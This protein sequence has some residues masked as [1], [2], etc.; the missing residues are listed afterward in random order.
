MNFPAS[1]TADR[2]ALAGLA[3]LA[4]LAFLVAAKARADLAQAIGDKTISAAS[5]GQ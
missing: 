2:I 3:I 1:L 4:A 5:G